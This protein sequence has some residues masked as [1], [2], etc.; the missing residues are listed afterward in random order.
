M[1]TGILRGGYINNSEKLMCNSVLTEYDTENE[2]IGN[3]RSKYRNT[4][5]QMNYSMS[6]VS[7][8]SL[9][10]NNPRAKLTV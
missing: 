9:V 2:S 5:R 10:V 6:S 3:N 4:M 7:R 1:E 8:T